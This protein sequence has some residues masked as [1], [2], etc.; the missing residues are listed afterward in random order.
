MVT[1]PRVLLGILAPALFATCA[2]FF[3]CSSKSSGGSF[4]D[5]GGPGN[6][7]ADGASPDPLAPGNTNP[8]PSFSSGDA[9]AQLGT[10]QSGEY[11][12]SFSCNFIW[13]PSAA[14]VSDAGPEASMATINGMLGFL[15]TQDVTA[16]GELSQTDTASGHLDL[17]T[18]PFTGSANLNGTLDCSTGRFVGAL[19]D[20]GYALG[21]IPG[22]SFNGS[23]ASR[24]D[25]LSL[26]FVDGTWSMT[27]PGLGYCPGTWSAGYLA[28]GG[29]GDQ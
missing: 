21:P 19:A 16:T 14:G 7:V 24:Y 11:G 18:G 2:V 13:D 22:G 3:G 12:G 10:C 17:Q 28:D 25:S 4:L 15:L 26:S 8:T 23:L 5:I 1:V 9:G 27:I 6:E 29:A 20:G